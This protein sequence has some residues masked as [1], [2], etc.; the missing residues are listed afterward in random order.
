MVQQ[1]EISICVNCKRIFHI[2]NQNGF[3]DTQTIFLI[4]KYQ[5]LGVILII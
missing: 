1:L 3:I 4:K 2:I 5:M